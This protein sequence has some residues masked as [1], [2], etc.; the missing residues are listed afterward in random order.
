MASKPTTTST[1]TCTS[2]LDTALAAILSRRQAR[3]LLRQLTLPP[4]PNPSSSR[5]VPPP[6]P[7]PADFSSN[8]YLSLSH[9][10]TIQTCFLARLQQEASERDGRGFALGARGSRLL[11]GNS[12]LATTLEARIAAF[13]GAAAG[14][15]FNSAFDANVGLLGCVP[16]P[17]DAVV[18]DELVHASAHDG[19]R[20]SRVVPERRRAF[21]HNNVASLRAVLEELVAH[22]AG[23]V[24]GERNAFV[25][26]EG[27]YSMDGD[28]APLRKVVECVEKCL[29]RGNGYVIVDE[30]HSTGIF[31][32]KGRG[33]VCELGLEAR[34][35][36]R[37]LG[38]GKAMGCAGGRLLI[39][40]PLI[41]YNRPDGS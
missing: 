16:Q 11:D 12:A 36:A 22:D 2:G 37:V 7:P 21:A 6:L 29:P 3:N 28:V 35:W 40:S 34:V 13:H 15:L 4:S 23:Y 17:G 18:Y 1:T 8:D 20:L 27:V 14:L 39:G 25:L 33:L 19:M 31:G 10:R 41:E 38:F 24:N 9:N 26:V 32:E 5:R 30:A